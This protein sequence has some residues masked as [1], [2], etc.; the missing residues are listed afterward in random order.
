MNNPDTLNGL[1][2]HQWR[3]RALDAEARTAQL[4][5]TIKEKDEA[6]ARR[7]TRIWE[8]ET[9]ASHSTP[10][11]HIQAAW[12]KAHPVPVGATIP[13]GTP[14]LDRDVEGTSYCPGG[15]GRPLTIGANSE[16]EY[17]TLTPL[18]EHEP[19]EWETSRFIYADEQIYERIN[20][21]MGPYWMDYG[22]FLQMLDRDEVAKLNPRPIEIK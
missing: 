17:R 19:E 15:F 9:S 10:A 14:I 21:K 20:D 8:L 16:V 11:E 7:N 2:I 3:D 5:G 13:A 18:P 6:L 22:S 1:T 4:K 12:D